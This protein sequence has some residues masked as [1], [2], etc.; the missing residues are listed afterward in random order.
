MLLATASPQSP[1]PSV[2]GVLA[3]LEK[4][5]ET[6]RRTQWICQPLEIDDYSAQPHPDV[7]PPKWHLG[8]TT[9]F[10]ETLVLG[11][12]LPNYSAFD[13]QYQY[14]FNSY[15]K[16]LG[17]HQP[18]SLRGNLTRPPVKQVYQYRQHVDGHIRQM[19]QN[20]PPKNLS[21]EAYQGNFVLD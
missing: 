13:P 1:S 3:L 5:E 17:V 4:Y 2:S 11:K 7:S 12:C 9:W 6:R 18:R 8:H 10:F 16:S 19:L 14:L 20:E 21:P 15:Y